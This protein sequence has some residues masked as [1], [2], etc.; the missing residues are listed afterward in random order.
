M[1][2][3][4]NQSPD[5]LTVLFSVVEQASTIARVLSDYSMLRRLVEEH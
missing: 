1:M 5:R 3:S 4:L 2:G